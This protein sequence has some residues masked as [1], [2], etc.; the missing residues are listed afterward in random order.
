L[1][2]NLFLPNHAHSDGLVYVLQLAIHP[3]SNNQDDCTNQACLRE[4]ILAM[5]S[6]IASIK[7][8]F[9]CAANVAFLYLFKNYNK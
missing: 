6:Y 9:L 2:S 8:S 7:L 5:Y 3:S 1:G 4:K